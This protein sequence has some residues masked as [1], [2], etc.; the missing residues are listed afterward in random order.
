MNVLLKV[1][2]AIQCIEENIWKGNH[3]SEQLS[4]ILTE[5]EAQINSRLLTYLGAEPND[6]KAL[7]PAQVLI[8]RN[9]QQFPSRDTNVKEHT[10]SAL[11]KRGQRSVNGFWRR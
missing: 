10:T 2:S 9:L 1:L 8:G 7:T 5:I 6:F 4:T 11:K 3:D